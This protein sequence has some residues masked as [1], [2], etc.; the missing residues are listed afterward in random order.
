M[1]QYWTNNIFTHYKI[2]DL[3][4]IVLKLATGKKPHIPVEKPQSK[5]NIDSQSLNAFI[6]QDS[7]FHTHIIAN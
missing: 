4:S 2:S 5:C 3:S 7:L 6:A 1:L